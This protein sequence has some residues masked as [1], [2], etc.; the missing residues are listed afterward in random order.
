MFI[1]AYIAVGQKTDGV[2]WFIKKDKRH[3]GKKRP[4]P[5]LKFSMIEM[6]NSVHPRRVN[7][8]AS[9]GRHHT[10]AVKSEKSWSQFTLNIVSFY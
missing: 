6:S 5:I 4:Q 1:R 3:L 9:Y 7:G 8:T 10:I 2:Q